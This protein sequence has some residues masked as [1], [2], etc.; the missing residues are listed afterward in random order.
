MSKN[1]A[2][3]KL[4]L[5]FVV[6][7]C[8]WCGALA[9][10]AGQ[11]AYFHQLKL[12]ER[13]PTQRSYSI[14][15]AV[16][17]LLGGPFIFVPIARIVGRTLVIFWSLI[18][19]FVCQIWAACMTGSDDYYAFI[20]SR[21]FASLFGSPSTILDAGY[22]IDLFFLHQ[23]GRAFACYELSLLL[24]TGFARGSTATFYPKAPTSFLQ[25]RIATLLPGNRVAP[26]AVIAGLYMLVSFGFSIM[27]AIQTAIYLQTPEKH[28]GYGFTAAQNAAF[29]F[30]TWLTVLVAQGI[31]LLMSDRLPLWAAQ[32]FNKGVWRPEYRVW[33][34][35]LSA[36]LAPIGF[37]IFG[38]TLQ[39]HYH[40]MLLALGSFLVNIA[41]QLSV[42][43]LIN[44]IIEC[45]I[46]H[47]VEVSVAM[48][49]WRLAFG[50]AVGFAVEPWAEA[51][52]EG[53]VYGMASLFV[54]GA[55][56]LTA[57]L[58]WKGDRLRKLY[59]L[60]SLAVSEEGERVAPDHA[61]V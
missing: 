19:T 15:A 25:S 42:P 36:V 4:R 53:W 38:V 20:A 3:H 8:A 41:S 23:R 61:D 16:A 55:S 39:Y 33:N 52:G 21:L 60:K 30:V 34:M 37:A 59:P 18:G 6:C 44:C 2:H 54:F 10:P 31:S 9:P 28:G 47:P 13:T 35:W 14:N 58:A 27:L 5:L 12:Y 1:G 29:T 48:N 32:R 7:W 22:I 43:L 40:Y 50:I 24:E 11:L 45:F 49:T 56:L 57:L 17:G 51:V 26:L 46:M